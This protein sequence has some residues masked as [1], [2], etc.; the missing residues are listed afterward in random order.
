MSIA[1]TKAARILLAGSLFLTGFAPVLAEEAAKPAA[2]AAETKAQWPEVLAKIGDQ[3]ITRADAFDFMVTE[4]ARQ[5]QAQ[6]Y[7]IVS[8]A[9]D[10]LIASKLIEAAAAK[11][12]KGASEWLQ[13]QVD[14]RAAEP[15]AKEIEDT[16]NQ[17][18]SRIGDQTLEQAKPLIVRYL[19]NQQGQA[20]YG[21]IVE[22]LRSK[23]NVKV[24]VEPPRFQVSDAGRPSVGP[25]DAPVTIV[26]FSDYQCPFCSRA[27]ATVK[28]V[29]DTYGNNVRVVFR[30]F[31]LSFHQ[32]A[33]KAAEAA[34]CA[35]EQ[36][37][38]WPM[39]DKLFA[40][41]GALA[42]DDLK[43]YAGEVGLD[44]K[45]FD[46]CLTSN[47]RAEPIKKDMADGG[48]VGVQ[49]TPGFFIN[50]RFL[51]GAVPFD[52][53]AAII[54][55]ELKAKG[56]PIPPKTKPAA[57]AAEAKPAEKPADAKPA[58]AKD[59]KPAAKGEGKK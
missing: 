12:K 24:L 26:T 16:Y 18:K 8:S 42:V 46:E 39:H 3:T 6:P 36:G 15:S 53:F 29:R 13:E 9:I 31:P 1:A 20:I 28:E 56:L 57:P 50:G 49:G 54:D 22:E 45:K 23:A 58:A 11:D 2:P 25:K 41:Q 51:N 27:E 14:K 40:N 21:Q 43:K 7:E 47:R 5:S 48:A 30:D 10:Q 59:A 33:E 32:N 35:D 17:F 55:D 4:V 52:K 44:A 19:K 38:F 34:G 37:K